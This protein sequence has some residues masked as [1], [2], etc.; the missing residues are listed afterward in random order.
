[1]I[2]TNICIYTNNVMVSDDNLELEW[3][4]F[5]VLD[6]ENHKV[7]LSNIFMNPVKK[8]RFSHLHKFAKNGVLHSIHEDKEYHD[9]VSKPSFYQDHVCIDV[10]NDDH[11]KYTKK[12]KYEYVLF[13]FC[14]SLLGFLLFKLK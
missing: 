11:E 8:N 13:Y 12:N 7:I 6:E 10:E 14:C 5:V 4:Q 3:G 1:M 2:G 9:N